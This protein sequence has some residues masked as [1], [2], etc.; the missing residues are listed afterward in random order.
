MTTPAHPY[1][2]CS[3]CLGHHKPGDSC[4]CHVCFVEMHPQFIH[5]ATIEG[6]RFSLCPNCDNTFHK[7]AACQALCDRRHQSLSQAARRL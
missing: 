5:C 6:K 1:P 3:H 7:L 4:R 2:E